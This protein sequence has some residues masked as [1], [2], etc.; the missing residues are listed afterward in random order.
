MLHAFLDM[1]G[2]MKPDFERGDVRLYLG[3]S[4]LILPQLEEHI[5]AV[6]VD[7]PYG[8][9]LKGKRT[10]REAS[11]V[12]DGYADLVDDASTIQE[13][14]LPVM[15]HCLDAYG[16]VVCFP[17]I[18]A[19][20]QYPEPADVG[21]VFNP[22]GAGLGRWGFTCWHPILYYGKDPY[23]ANGMGHR[24]NGF[25]D[26]AAG[27]KAKVHPCA[28]PIRWMEFAVTKAA[29]ERE[30]VLDPFMGSGTTG[31]ACLRLGRKFVGIEQHPPY[32]AEAVSRLER[33]FDRLALFQESPITQQALPGF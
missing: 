29:L 7:P 33:E 23:L 2:C 16:R 24:P 6:V 18:R 13:V 1:T 8:V 11:L 12:N 19:M 3:D 26:I 25:Q 21:G 30:T 32:F 28:K 17:G 9:G 31:I 20:Y 10:K 27:E 22:S 4:R 15:R 5:D 14:V